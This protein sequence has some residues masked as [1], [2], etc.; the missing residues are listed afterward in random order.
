MMEAIGN[1]KVFK[2]IALSNNLYLFT[3]FKTIIL[4]PVHSKWFV[5]YVFCKNKIRE[6]ESQVVK[7]NSETICFEQLHTKQT[8]LLIFFV[9]KASQ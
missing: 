9:V 2:I 3:G 6:N 7:L 1:K 8:I 4:C 5:K